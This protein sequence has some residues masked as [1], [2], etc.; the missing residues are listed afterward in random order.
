MDENYQF[1]WTQFEKLIDLHKFYFENLIKAAIF[2][3]GI[4]GA[5]FTYAIKA[6][7]SPS[8]VRISLVLPLILSIGTCLIFYR[9]IAMA[10]EFSNW[11]EMMKEEISL[12]WRPHTETLPQ[13]CQIFSLLFLIVSIGLTVVIFNPSILVVI[14]NRHS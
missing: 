9:G 13:M 11:V 12:K 2:S 4:I 7:L 10:Q 1:K 3:F 5:I 8:L 14:T 6:E